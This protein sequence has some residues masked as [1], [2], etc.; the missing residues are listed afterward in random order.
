M[1]TM[2]KQP[3]TGKAYAIVCTNQSALKLDDLTPNFTF[4]DGEIKDVQTNETAENVAEQSIRYVPTIQRIC[5]DED[6]AKYAC[7]NLMIEYQGTEVAFHVEEVVLDDTP[8]PD[9][10]CDAL[11]NL[12][13][14]VE[15]KPIPTS[16]HRPYEEDIFG[17]DDQD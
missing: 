1:A 9:F 14:K 15:V 6:T 12:L 3:T 5:M 4:D 17:H 8:R 13:D 11:E 16:D 10:I 7:V 2:K